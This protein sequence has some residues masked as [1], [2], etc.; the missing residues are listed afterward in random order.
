MQRKDE[1]ATPASRPKR[2]RARD[3]A[4]L[5]TAIAD[6]GA[7]IVGCG[8]LVDRSAGQADVSGLP[9]YSLVQLTVQAWDPADCPL[10]REGVPLEKPGSRGSA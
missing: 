4:R 2:P 3:L 9:L 6:T 7:D 5:Y 10:C 1:R 8:C